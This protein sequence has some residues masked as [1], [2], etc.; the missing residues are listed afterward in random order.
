MKVRTPWCLFLCLVFSHQ[1]ISGQAQQSRQIL[2]GHVRA[3]VANGQAKQLGLL[4]PAQRLELAIVL[5]LRNQAELTDLLKRLYDPSSPDYRQFLSVAEF[6]D[7]FGPTAEDCHAVVEFAI[8]NGFTVG[9]VPSNRMIVP[10]S[11]TVEQVE[12]AFDVK[13]KRYQHPTENREFFSPDREP[14]VPPGLK[15]F[16]IGGLD[17]YSIPRPAMVKPSQDRGPA[18]ATVAGSGPGGAYLSSDMRAAYYGG[19]SLTGTGQT[20]ALVQFDGYNISD[21]VGTF[22]GT[23]TA[24][25]NGTDYVIN[26]TPSPGGPTY[27][28]PIHNVLLDG[29]T[30]EPGQYTLGDVEQSVDIAQV[31]GMAPGLSQ[32]RVYIAPLGHD[33]AVFSAIASENIAK[34]VSISW[35]W[36]SPSDTLVDDVFFQEFAAQGQS[37]FAASGDDGTFAPW[38]GSYPA[39]SA[40]VTSVGG[41]SLTTEG[42]GGAWSSETAWDRSGG[43]INLENILIPDWQVLAIN[44][45]NGGSTTLRNAPDVAMEADTDNYACDLGICGGGY[46]GTSFAAPRWAGLMAL[47]NQ[48]AA[49]SGSAPV[50]FVNPAIYA[51]SEGSN[52]GNM[53]HDIVSG[54]NNY[55]GFQPLAYFN[56]VPGYDLVTGWGSP[57]GQALIDAL[58]PQAPA[59]F[60]LSSSASILNI[61]PG[62]QGTSTISVV[63]QNGFSSPVNLAVSGLPQGVTSSFSANPGTGSSVLTLSVGSSAVRGSYDVIVTGTSGSTQTNVSLTLNV[64]APGFSILFSPSSIQIPVGA[65]A[66]ATVSV[67]RYGGFTGDVNLAITSPMPG[68]LT[69][70]WS[71]NPTSESSELTLTTTSASY[72][73]ILTITGTSG[74]LSASAPL[75]L[76]TVLP[77]FALDIAPIPSTI[78]QGASVTTNVTLIPYGDLTSTISLSTTYAPSGVTAT[79]NPTSLSSGQTSLLNLSASTSAQLGPARVC[80]YGSGGGSGTGGC[81]G[82][83]VTASPASAFTLGLSQSTLTL[84]QGTSA[85]ESVTVTPQGGFGGAVNLTLSGLPSGVTASFSPNP[86]TGNSVLTFQASGS[87]SPGFYQIDVL[88]RSGSKSAAA[89]IFLTVT[90]VPSFSISPSGSSLTVAPGASANET[91]N[92]IPHF[93]FSGAV[94][95]SVASGLPSGVSASF[96]PDP[97][98]GTSTLTLTASGSTLTGSYI[99]NIAGN[100]GS[101][102]EN[103]TVFLTVGSTAGSGTTTTLSMSPTPGASVPLG[104]LYMLTAAVTSASGPVTKGQVKFCDTS[105]PSCTDLHLLG[106]AQLTNTGTAVLKFH[107]PAGNHTYAAE[108]MGVPGGSPSYPGSSSAPVSISIVAPTSTVILSSGASGNYTLTATVAGSGSADAPSGDVSFL[109]TSE[110]NNLLASSALTGGAN[111]LTFS[112]IST[113]DPGNYPASVAV[114][115]FNGDGKLDIAVANQQ[116]N[117]VAVFWGNG[118]GTFAAQ[119]TIAVGNSPSSIMAGDFNNDGIVDL[120]VVNQ[121]ENT[122]SILLGNGDGTFNAASFRPGTGEE[123][124]GNLCMPIVAG[125]F[126]QDGNLDLAVVNEYDDS[127]TILLGNGDGTFDVANT[128]TTGDYPDSIAIGDFNGDGIPDLAVLNSSLF[129][130]AQN[131]TITILLGNGD[132][133][134]TSMPISPTSGQYPQSIAAGDLNG[135]GIPDLVVGDID[136]TLN[137][138]LGNGNGMFTPAPIGPESGGAPMAIAVGDLNG[139]GNLDLAVANNNNAVKLFLGNGDGTFTAAKTTPTAGTQV[140]SMAIGDFNGDGLP[141]LIALQNA[142]NLLTVAVSN[143]TATSAA[144]AS[145]MIEGQGTHEVDA[146]YSG[147]SANSSSTSTTVTLDGMPA[148]AKPT[149]SVSSG[150]YTSVQSVA[151]SD[152][153][154]GAVIHYTTNGT[155]PTTSSTLYSGPITVSTTETL[156]AIATASG[157][158]QSAIASAAYT[159]ELPAATPTFSVSPGTYTSAQSVS[160]SDTTPGAVIHYTTNGTT[161][162]INSTLYSGPIT[163]S[164]SETIEAIATASGY[165]QSAVASAAYV[166]DIPGFGPPA[167][168]QPGSISIQP[169]ATTGNTVTISV[170]GTN[171]FAGTVNLTCAV[172]TSLTDVRYMP[173]CNLNPTSVTLSGTAAQTS[174]LTVTTTAASAKSDINKLFGSMTG[175]TALALIV[176]FVIP[177]RRRNWTA[178]LGLVILF[179]S[180]NA[181]GCGG[182]GSGGNGGGGGGGNPGTTAGTYTITVTGI[183]GSTTATLGTV[184]LYVL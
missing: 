25:N 61:R 86:T 83:T 158:S 137:I 148:A 132:G 145:V 111:S 22:G 177:R 156:Q 173:T 136:G 115:D 174:T 47:A 105:S 30:G 175:G 41:T 44:G 125:D 99:L 66:T 52:Y 49:A 23:A 147:D 51:I 9:R 26:Y 101:E 39:E 84:V 36:N 134:F 140:S 116:D 80:I 7:R 8:S 77:M 12:K 113:F 32:V 131:S 5:P 130:G 59:G 95:F 117:A 13:M 104:T 33:A 165:S 37:V 160:I 122:L 75:V 27:S 152:M 143:L 72:A 135:D 65:T 170:V 103:A 14:S 20:I 114:G 42:D 6:T 129:I 81:F 167:G 106:T 67:I 181:I 124:S 155:T 73:S 108:Y 45:T 121:G 92:V 139:D 93:G 138:L 100:S 76:D 118:D 57:V 169:G 40:Y 35:L 70:T 102:T 48:Q 109:D 38:Y 18:N 128:P 87:A 182:G 82:V 28:V 46:G 58:A 107:P 19:S 142:N 172:A 146:Q 110:S 159:I 164:T 133:T 176:F 1:I 64:D 88:G 183:S 180:V 15:F 24:T 4:P 10:I 98:S 62:N 120:A 112:N 60:Q 166:I 68:G 43:G 127:V 154:P 168:Y 21:A 123:S 55:W 71:K 157:F 74:D 151:I 85:S 78:S 96:S 97:S 50:G 153:T 144:S 16:H 161:P 56:A 34:Q 54:N 11:A 17:N 179:V 89:M 141:D 53:F 163:V 162:T 126:N 69:A 91:L 63:A 178:M 29:A 184:T 2:P 171:G 31:I 150:T 94:N 79:F 90:A 149:F 119:S 3:A